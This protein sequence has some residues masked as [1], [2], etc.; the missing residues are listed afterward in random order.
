MLQSKN[1][2]IQAINEYIQLSEELNKHRLSTKDIHKLLNLLLAAKEYMYDQGKIVAK[3]RNLKHLKNKENRLKR[4][5]EIL[6]G[7]VK[8]CKFIAWPACF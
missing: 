1:V 7:Q 6:S 8:E 4:H 2:N 5:C 3:L